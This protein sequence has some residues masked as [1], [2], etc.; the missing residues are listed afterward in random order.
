MER[1]TATAHIRP[2]ERGERPVERGGR[3]VERERELDRLGGAVEGARRGRGAL[4][5]VE[6]HAGIGASRLLEATS[7]SAARA[8]VTVLRAR[9]SELETGVAHGV[10]LQLLEPVV[11]G[12]SA[13]ERRALLADAA[14]LAEPLLTGIPPASCTSPGRLVSP[15]HHAL[16][17]IVANLA[18]GAPALLVVDDAQWA[19]TASLRFLAHLA[20]RLDRLPVAVVVAAHP[21]FAGK[22]RALLERL[23]TDPAAELIVPPPLSAA[24]VTSML[25]DAL[26]REPDEAFGRACAEVTGGVPFLVRELA[27]ALARE[28]VAPREASAARV[29]ATGTDSVARTVLVRISRLPRG[30]LELARATSVLGDGAPLRHAAELAGLDVPSA[31]TAVDALATDGLLRPGEPLRFMHPIVRTSIHAGLPRA[32]RAQLHTHAARLLAR[33]GLPAERIGAQLI[34]GRAQGDAWTVATLE[35]AAASALGRGAPRSAARYLRR[36]LRAPDGSAPR[37]RGRRAGVR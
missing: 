9:G 15:P 1:E 24:G 27:R 35:T 33:D 2:V 37:P 10:V 7:Q 17:R 34:P 23:A 28:R 11:A 29:L 30:S 20:A 22:S 12:A 5:V 8:G 6:G 36:A 18:A 16:F 31:G 13:G 21:T 14:A 4:V 32:R 26:G 25:R 19:D 3:L